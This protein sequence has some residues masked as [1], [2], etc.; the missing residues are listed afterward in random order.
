MFAVART[1]NTRSTKYAN[2]LFAFVVVSEV[3]NI[4]D[5]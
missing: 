2:F 4:D 5:C 1:E 3:P